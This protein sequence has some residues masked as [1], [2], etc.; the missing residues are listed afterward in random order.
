MKWGWKPL[1]KDRNKEPTLGQKWYTNFWRQNDHLLEK[2]KRQ[3]F[4]KD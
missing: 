3:K 2:K 4:S 1:D